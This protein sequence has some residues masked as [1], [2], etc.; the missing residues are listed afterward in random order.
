MRVNSFKENFKIGILFKK[1]TKNKSKLKI[2]PCDCRRKH[3]KINQ[4]LKK[5]EMSQDQLRRFKFLYLYIIQIIQKL[6][7]HKDPMSRLWKN[8][9]LEGLQ[10]RIQIGVQNREDFIFRGS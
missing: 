4:Q 1:F 7:L 10:R 5:C 2:F 8:Q 9:R 6:I 3:K